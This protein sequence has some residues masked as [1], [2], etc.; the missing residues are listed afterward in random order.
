MGNVRAR[1]DYSDVID[2]MD[3]VEIGVLSDNDLLQ[4]DSATNL[5]KNETAVNVLASFS[6]I[7]TS[8]FSWN[9]QN[10]TGIGTL[11]A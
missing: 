6:G 3:D 10:L 4:Y 7:A 5:W 2:E 1:Y 9:G 11:G 8:D